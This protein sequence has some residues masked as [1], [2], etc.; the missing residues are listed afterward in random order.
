MNPHTWGWLGM[1]RAIYKA[2]VGELQKIAR[3]KGPKWDKLKKFRVPLEPEERAEVMRREATWNHGPKGEA[4]PAVQKSIID[5]Q[6]WYSMAT[7]RAFNVRP[8]LAGAIS[9]K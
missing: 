5:G 8:T 6:T 9:R 7:H 4:T 2:F 1:N 3:E